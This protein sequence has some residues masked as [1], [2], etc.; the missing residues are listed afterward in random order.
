MP[1]SISAAKH[2][3]HRR[4]TMVRFCLA[5]VLLCLVAAPPLRAFEWETATARGREYVT[6]RSFCTFYGF[7]YA[8]PSGNSPFVSRNDAH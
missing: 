7:G 1:C 2:W 8:V 6:L 3:F 4:A 5:L